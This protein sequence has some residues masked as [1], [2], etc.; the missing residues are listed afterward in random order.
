[1]NNEGRTKSPIKDLPVHVPGQSLDKHIQE[2]IDDKVMAYF[3]LAAFMIIFA[4][5]E[6]YRMFFNMKPAPGTFTLAAILTVGYCVWRMKK[7][8]IE[9]ER[10]KLGRT[11]ERAVGQFL[12]EHLRPIGCNVLHDIP[13][14]GFNIDHVVIGPTGVYTIETKTHSKPVKGPA[15]VQYDGQTVKVNG[16]TPDRDPL[17]QAKANAHSLAELIERSTGRKVLVKPVVLYPGWFVDKTPDG[18]EVWVL[19]EKALPAF[20]SNAKKILPPEDVALITFH[21]KRFVISEDQK[22]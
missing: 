11:G 2:V 3:L 8:V 17:V 15:S 12:E 1:M 4:A 6:W 14:D 10:L 5:F 21:L 16:F 20:V 9:V 13:G 19:N 7:G 22:Q 18:A